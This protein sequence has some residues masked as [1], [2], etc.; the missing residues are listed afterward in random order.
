LILGRLALALLVLL[1][2]TTPLR[3]AD[4]ARGQYLAEAAGCGRCHTTGEA[5]APSYAGGRVFDTQFGPLTSPN[6]T[7]DRATG[8]GGWSESDFIRAMRW[9]IAPDD[10]HYV[11]IFPFLY[12]NRLTDRDLADIKAF[13]DTLPPVSSPGPPRA[14]SMALW[15]RTR[16]AVAIAATPMHGPWHDDPSKDAVWNRGAY[17]IATIGRC[18]QCHTPRTWLGIPDPDRFLAGGL[19]RNGRR[20]PNIT[21]SREAGIGHWSTDDIVTMLTDGTTPN[22]DEVGGSMAETV[23]NTARLSEEDRRAIAVYLQSVPP[24]PGPEPK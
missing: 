20:A 11:P 13:L 12:Y 16:A 14:G 5:G 4:S 23:K 3:A 24:V 6:I 1:G 7:P 2:G 22:F 8:I 15:E 9:G 10:S 17:L 21:P 19:D 18:G